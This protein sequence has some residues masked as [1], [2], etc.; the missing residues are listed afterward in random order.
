MTS[1]NSQITNAGERLLDDDGQA[2]ATISWD[3]GATGSATR[4]RYEFLAHKTVR[5]TGSKRSLIA[6]GNTRVHW[7]A[8]REAAEFRALSDYAEHMATTR[9]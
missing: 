4:W 2:V 8:D 6:S 5:A 1:L 3:V 7:F 9:Y